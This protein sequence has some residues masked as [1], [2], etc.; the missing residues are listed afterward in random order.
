MQEDFSVLIDP[1]DLYGI[2][3]SGLLIREEDE[4]NKFISILLG[5]TKM[6][7]TNMMIT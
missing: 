6:K 3:T 4:P 2:D 1:D 7:L 5:H